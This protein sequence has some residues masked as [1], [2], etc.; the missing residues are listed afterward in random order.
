[1]SP[2]RWQTQ[3]HVSVDPLPPFWRDQLADR[4]GCRPRRIGQ[5]TE[6]AVYGALLCLDAALEL[7]LPADAS[8]RVASLSGPRVATH[9]IIEQARTG[10]PMP[11]SFMQSQPSQMLAAISRYLKW[12]GDASFSVCRNRQMVI[13]LAQQECGAAGAL[14]G[15]VEEDQ[16]T[17]WWRIRPI[18]IQER[19]VGQIPFR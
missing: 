16:A 6:L 5:W 18:S 12:Q 9:D 1:M 4:L 10:V 19:P 3:A 7:Q 14:I 15:W 11:F 2:T 8:I 17:E 13:Q